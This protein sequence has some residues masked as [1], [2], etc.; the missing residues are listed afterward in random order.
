MD[1]FSIFLYLICGLI[2][3]W[4]FGLKLLLKLMKGCKAPC[5][6]SV[7]WIVENPLRERYMRSILSRVGVQAGETVLEIG[8]GPGAFTIDA[9]KRVGNHGKIIAVDIQ[10][11][12]ISKLVKK[13]ERS[14]ITNVSTH[15]ANA[16]DLPI[17]DASVDR[18]FLVTVL[19]EI[20]DPIRALREMYRVLKPNGIL[21]ISEEFLDPDYPLRS[22]TTGWAISAGFTPAGSFGNFWLY[23]LNF[24]K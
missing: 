3:I 11:E 9:A 7:S 23:T 2:F 16:Y 10:P 18:I 1:L 19:P 4:L 5:P 17:D 13:L 12:M 15:V 6:S 14:G 22:T 24:Q 8:P 21:S 20:P